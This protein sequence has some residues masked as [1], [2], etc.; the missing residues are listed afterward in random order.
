MKGKTGRR[1]VES[2]LLPLAAWLIT[3]LRVH[4]K[5]QT[6]RHWM[7]GWFT[8]QA[9]ARTELPFSIW[10]DSELDFDTWCE[11]KGEFTHKAKKDALRKTFACDP[12]LSNCRVL[13]RRSLLEAASAKSQKSWQVF[14]E[15]RGYSPL[16]HRDVRSGKAQPHI[17]KWH[18]ETQVGEVVADWRKTMSA[19]W[20]MLPGMSFPISDNLIV[21]LAHVLSDCGEARASREKSVASQMW[22]SSRL[23][24]VLLLFA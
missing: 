24:H 14:S 16:L 3:L 12:S 1:R 10:T 6:S 23:M 22:K 19:S 8:H 17:T 2:S 18:I 13:R 20:T 7:S 15:S 9:G 5:I 21:L 11:D 4:V